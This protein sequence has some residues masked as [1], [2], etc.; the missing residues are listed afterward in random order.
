[1]TYFFTGY[2]PLRFTGMNE[3]RTAKVVLFF[4]DQMNKLYT[5]EEYLELYPFMK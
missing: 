4:D 2:G 3:A 1:V 5:E